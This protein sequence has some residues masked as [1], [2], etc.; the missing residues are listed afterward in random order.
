M[1]ESSHTPGLDIIFGAF[2]SGNYSRALSPRWTAE[3]TIGGGVSRWVSIANP[4]TRKKRHEQLRV[5]KAGRQEI[6][7]SPEH[8]ALT[9][10]L[11]GG[12]GVNPICGGA[13]GCNNSNPRRD[14]A[15][16][17]PEEIPNENCKTFEKEI[18][19]A[20]CRHIRCSFHV[21]F[22][23]CKAHTH[24]IGIHAAP[25][26]GPPSPG[27][28]I[29][30]TLLFPLSCGLGCTKTCE[31][32]VFYNVFQHLCTCVNIKHWKFYIQFFFGGTCKR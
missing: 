2:L 22:N 6:H 20:R 1:F 23:E 3:T 18:F 11:T 17:I 4:P 32:S 27:T 26:Q 12:N 31:D 7:R 28:K 30:Q 5:T 14:S 15:Q 16:G 25:R 21:S 8:T 9:I 29:C 13:A 19:F 24:C 10:P